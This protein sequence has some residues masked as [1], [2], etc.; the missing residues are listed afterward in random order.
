ML[1]SSFFADPHSVSHRLRAKLEHFRRVA[2]TTESIE[3]RA[4]LDLRRAK[5]IAVA[6]T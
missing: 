6:V 3:W 4:Q 1:D 5:A 2:W